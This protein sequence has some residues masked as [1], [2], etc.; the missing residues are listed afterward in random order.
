MEEMGSLMNHFPGPGATKTKIEDY[1][2]AILDDPE[3]TRALLTLMSLVIDES[4]VE[5]EEVTMKK[6]KP[7][8]PM[9]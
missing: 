2:E 8:T 6:G 1:I 3:D 9:Y 5:E 7:S 4:S